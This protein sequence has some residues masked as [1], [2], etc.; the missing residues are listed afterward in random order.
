MGWGAGIVYSSVPAVK[1]EAV[2]QYASH[3]V[4]SFYNTQTGIIQGWG[5]LVAALL[6]VLFFFINYFGVRLFSRINTTVTWIKFIMPV[7]TIILFLVVGSHWSNLSNHR[8]GPGGTAGILQAVATSGVI[9][10]YLGFRQAIDLAGEAKNPQR[11][12]PRA[13]ILAIGIGI[14]LYVLLQLVFVGGLSPH[15]LVKGWAAIS[16]NAP[17]AEVAAALN[18]GWL[19]V[20]L[21]ADAVFSPAGTAIFTSP[22]PRPCFMPSPTTATFPRRCPEWIRRRASQAS[23]CSSPSYLAWSSCW[24]FPPG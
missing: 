13:V 22:P 15:D 1:A 14:V 23:P 12:V 18:L 20:L 5:I 4:P 16:F 19:S 3:Y 21:Y 7:M 10:A 2:V 9:F 24:P 17:F 11:D 8:F 6:L